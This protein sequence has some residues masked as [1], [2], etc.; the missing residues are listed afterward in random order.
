MMR[1]QV[2][3]VPFLPDLRGSG[4][5]NSAPRTCME[6]TLL[7]QPCP[8]P[9]IPP[10]RND[11]SCWRPICQFKPPSLRSNWRLGLRHVKGTQVNTQCNKFHTVLCNFVI[12]FAS[13]ASVSRH[14][15]FCHYER[16]FLSFSQS[17]NLCKGT[18][19]MLTKL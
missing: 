8:Q 16:S 18:L 19:G 2:H 10:F 11:P 5:S 7:T 14:L 15:G 1:R 13:G 9:P 12:N 17:R 4:D 6:S 3:A